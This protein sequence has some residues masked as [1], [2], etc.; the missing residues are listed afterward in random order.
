MTRVTSPRNPK[1]AKQGRVGSLIRLS[2]V[3]AIAAA[4]LSSCSTLKVT[5]QPEGARVVWSPDGLEPWREWPPRAFGGKPGPVT[6]FAASGR[7]GDTIYVTVEKDGFRRPLPKVVQLY[8][9]RRNKLEFTMD[10]LPDA[11]SERKRLEGQVYYYGEWVDPEEMGLV[12]VDGTAMPREEAERL[13]MTAKGF[14]RWEEGWVL[15]AERERL[16]GEKMKAEGKVL[17]KDRW[18]APQVVELESGWDA[19]V[20]QVQESG[21]YLDLGAPKVLGRIDAPL[22]QIQVFNNSGKPTTVIFSGPTSRS[23]DLEPYQSWGIQPG[24]TMY[25]SGGRYDVVTLRRTPGAGAS[26]APESSATRASRSMTDASDRPAF[27]SQ[28]LVAGFQ[29]AFTIGTGEPLTPESL[30]AYEPPSVELPV[31]TK[32]IT[33]PDIDKVKADT[34]PKIPDASTGAPPGGGTG[35]RPPRNDGGGSRPSGGGRPRGPG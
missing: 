35:K 10:E 26:I 21:E 2:A 24:E 31:T 34:A 5:S 15:P 16:Y 32:E 1:S 6:P 9:F 33:V 4:A 12:V 17:Y 13:D 28:P 29:Y 22:A 23:I 8:T 30:A 27:T 7:Y 11:L 25:V 3:V 18:V 20:A 14:V 19:A